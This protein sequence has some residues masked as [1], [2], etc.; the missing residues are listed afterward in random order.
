MGALGTADFNVSNSF[1]ATFFAT[2]NNLF[3]VVL[4]AV[5]CGLYIG[6]ERT[7]SP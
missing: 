3:S 6:A 2:G 4:V 1:D 7:I 5:Q